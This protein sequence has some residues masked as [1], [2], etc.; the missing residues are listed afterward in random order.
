[1]KRLQTFFGTLGLS[2]VILTAGSIGIGIAIMVFAMI[3]ESMA[4]I[5]E[6]TTGLSV[7]DSMALGI[8]T[9]L[10]VVFSFGVA[11]YSAFEDKFDK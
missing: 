9:G 5:V 2:M 1:M 4:T 10:I 6:R 7:D 8:L 3:V 11:L